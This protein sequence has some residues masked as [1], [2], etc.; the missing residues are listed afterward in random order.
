MTRPDQARYSNIGPARTS[1]TPSA[2]GMNACVVSR[3][4]GYGGVGVFGL[5]SKWTRAAASHCGGFAATNDLNAPYAGL[6]VLP[7]LSMMP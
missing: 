4:N 1:V 5:L 3:L 2:L 7:S 6:G